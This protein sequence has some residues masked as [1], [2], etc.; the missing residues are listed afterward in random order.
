MLV[1]KK[2][3][4]EKLPS[5]MTPEELVEETADYDERD[6][7]GTPYAAVIR[8]TKKIRKQKLRATF[9]EL[10]PCYSP[11]TSTPF[12]S[13]GF[14][15]FTSTFISLASLTPSPPIRPPTEA[16]N[17][18]SMYHSIELTNLLNCSPLSIS[19]SFSCSN[20]S[21]PDGPC[22]PPREIFMLFIV[23]RGGGDRAPVKT[24]HIELS[25]KRMM[26]SPTASKAYPMIL[27]DLNRMFHP[28]NTLRMRL[29]FISQPNN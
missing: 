20:P 16:T 3:A 23:M 25:A 13:E 1:E 2:R 29:L 24:V 8:L 21:D 19:I 26:T 18:I 9:G 4:H 7:E 11:F 28:M 27:S 6:Y 15:V 22:S 17:S 12:T 14:S 10:L 5:E